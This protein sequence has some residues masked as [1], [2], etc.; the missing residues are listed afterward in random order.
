VTGKPS[1]GPPKGASWVW[2]TRELLSSDAWRSLANGRRFIDFLVLEHLNNGGKLNGNLKAPRRQLEDFGLGAHQI[3]A[4]IEEA[5]RSGLV[6][7][8]RPGERK[9]NFYALTWLPL[10]DGTLASDRWRLFRNPALKP[11]SKPKSKN[12]TVRKQ[13]ALT[14]NQQSDGRNL[15]V[16]KQSDTPKN[17]TADQHYPSRDLY[18][19]GGHS[20]DGDKRAGPGDPPAMP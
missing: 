8:K 19:G 7:C 1:N 17:L 6:D 11:L 15:T 18:Q 14:V 2:L 13:S 10:H 16:S 4:A 20:L 5:E 3:T 9:A 12:L